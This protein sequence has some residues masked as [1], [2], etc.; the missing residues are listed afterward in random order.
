MR[1]RTPYRATSATVRSDA[2]WVTVLE[3]PA[4]LGHS[5][6]LRAG[7]SGVDVRVILRGHAGDEIVDT[8]ALAAAGETRRAA[9]LPDVMAGVS[10]AVE[11]R[12]AAGGTSERDCRV[13]LAWVPF[14]ECHT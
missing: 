11:A 14:E 5:W 13:E 8:I 3:V 12:L 2:A 10:L 7:G 9:A 6:A 4:T 1:T